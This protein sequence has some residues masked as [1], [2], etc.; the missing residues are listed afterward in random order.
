MNDKIVESLHPTLGINEAT[1]QAELLKLLTPEEEQIDDEEF[2]DESPEGGEVSELDDIDEADEDIDDLDE[3]AELLEDEEDSDEELDESIET[4]TIKVDGENVQV[5]LNELKNGYSRQADYTRKSQAL[6]EERKTFTQDRDAVTIERQQYSQMLRALQTQLG[7]FDEPAPDFDQMYQ[8]DPIT[9]H[10]EERLYNRKQQ[11]RHQ[12]LVAIEAEQNRV[13]DATQKE[14]QEQMQVMLNSEVSRLG[15]LIPSWRDEA[16]AKKE[17]D[18]LRAYLGEQG[19]SENEIGAL[20]RAS[21]IQVLRKAMLY[22]Q[23]TKRVKKASK[24]RRRNAVSPGGRSSQ[25]KSSSKREKNQRARLAKSGRVE[26]A[27]ALI[28]SML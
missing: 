22:D 8:E 7:A 27:T 24:S 14:Q 2:A 21:H 18:E 20:V 1:A 25:V 23:G 4:F 6:S 15:E 13:A 9:A 10:R 12:K 11:E 19:I 17:S 28:E 3:D 26:D 16:V 5:D